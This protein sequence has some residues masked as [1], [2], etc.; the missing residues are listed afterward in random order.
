MKKLIK[1]HE[2]KDVTVKN[3]E[4]K[5]GAVPAYLMDRENT[6]NT[7]VLQNMIKQKRQEKAGKWQVPI[8]KVKSLTE[9]EM[10]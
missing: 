1:A 5:E 9:A 10:F 2:E 7:K 3:D 4:V 8:Q 6:S